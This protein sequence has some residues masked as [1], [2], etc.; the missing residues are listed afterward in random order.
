MAKSITDYLDSVIDEKG[1]RTYMDINISNATYIKAG[2]TAVAAAVAIIGVSYL[3]KY[4][5]KGGS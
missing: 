3:A 1:I 5:F 4:L 2:V